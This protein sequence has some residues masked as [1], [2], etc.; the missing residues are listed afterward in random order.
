MFAA[1]CALA[2]GSIGA[3]ANA[4]TFVETFTYT[5]SEQT[6][7]V[8]LGVT[9]MEV[10]AVGGRGG[11]DNGRGGPAARVTGELNVTPGETL[12]VEVG[13][14]GGEGSEYN[15]GGFNGGGSGGG[16]GGGASDVRTSPRSSGLSPDDRLL[17]AGGGGGGGR[18][19]FYSGGNG[20][21]AGTAGES[22]PANVGGEPGTQSSGGH[23]GEGGCS[24]GES[25]FLG[26]GGAGGSF[27]YPGGGGGGGYYGGG[28]GGAGC[29]NGGAGG[30]GGSSLVPAG[31]TLETIGPEIEPEIQIA[32][33]HML[34]P[35][36]VTEKATEVGSS[37]ATLNATVNPEGS[38]VTACYFEYGAT[39]SYG[40]TIP[41]SSSP[42]G[43]TSPVAVSAKVVGL[44]S[45]TS[46]HFRIAAE[47]PAAA[48][49]GSD[50][51]FTTTSPAEEL[52][53]I[54]RCVKLKKPTGKYLNAGCTTQSAEGAGSYEWS[55]GPGSASS[56]TF[57]NGAVTLQTV[58][59][60]QIK[61]TENTYS[62]RYTS[63]QTASV[64]L[65]LAGCEPSNRF[66]ITC[67][68]TGA[69]AGEV[70][71]NSMEGRFGFISEGSEPTV[72]L[73]LA[74][75]SKAFPY[76]AQFACG[77]VPVSITGS[78]IATYAP[79]NKMT[80]TFTVSFKET[81]GKQTPEAFE[82]G[83]PQLL[84]MAIGESTSEQTAKNPSH[85]PT[86]Q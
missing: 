19:G 4:A 69:P 7:T 39:S 31:G 79:L 17:V 78:V 73:A 24:G 21:G 64:N 5:G 33:Q 10:K 25:G 27:S 47:N 61:C 51:E 83:V 28:G 40:T 49:R 11:D 45:H 50:Q 38:E 15:S 18:T 59:K 70:D 62:G 14:T 66:G 58:S 86:N 6:F 34:A 3:V 63:P 37:S 68:S 9:S 32:Y 85:T 53:E 1:T 56:F 67:Q 13:G 75:D 8:P 65:K 35:T 12:Y 77:G 2:F 26:E 30:G 46:Y 42:G 44:A 57:K 82:G 84:S 71:F 76:M 60:I 80:A 22:I 81:A 23:G 72:G 74:P 52:P 41:C 36:V 29:S 54:G 20:G 43:G 48:S 55:A 16:G